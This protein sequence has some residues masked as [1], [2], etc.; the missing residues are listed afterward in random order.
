[1]LDMFKR[2][3]C[4][5]FLSMEIN[6]KKKLG[7]PAGSARF[8]AFLSLRV[9]PATQQEIARAAKV[10]DRPVV[11]MARVLLMRGLADWKREHPTK[12]RG[13]QKDTSK[14]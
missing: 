10:E 9:D 11:A 7:R 8:T 4:G 3:F 13:V 2:Y 5:I 12:G 14:G 6:E 1:M